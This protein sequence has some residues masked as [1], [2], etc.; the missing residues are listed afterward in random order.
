MRFQHQR[1]FGSEGP[2]VSRCG[3][4]QSA[5]FRSHVAGRLLI[6]PDGSDGLSITL[7]CAPARVAACIH[8]G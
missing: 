4:S 1:E 6:N 5:I 2:P 3:I 7:T 8:H